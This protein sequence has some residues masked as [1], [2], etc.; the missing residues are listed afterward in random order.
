MRK[1]LS[2]SVFLLISVIL[3]AGVNG[4]K[5]LKVLYIGGSADY[6]V[7]GVAPKPEDVIKRTE[8]FK[9]FL[10][11]YFDSVTV[12]NG[13]DYKPEISYNYD[14]TVIDG[15]IPVIK[16][17]ITERDANGRITKHIKAQLLPEDFDRAVVTI[18][19]VAELVGRA[20]GSKNDWYCLC[21]DADA[22]H[23]VEEHPIFKGPF[24][25]KLTFEKKPTPEDAFHYAYF[26]DGAMP[27]SLMMW[28]VQT[29]GYKTEKGFAV[30]MVSRPWGYTDS[31][32][33]EYIS[34]GVCAKTLDA[35]AIGRHGNFL[36]WGFAASPAYMT[37]EAKTVLANAICYMADFN[38]KGMIA[39]KYSDR[40]ATRE[41]LKE[42]VYMASDEAYTNRVASEEEFNAQCMK[43]RKVAEAKQKEG[44]ELSQNEKRYLNFEPSPVMSRADMLK[45]YQKEAFE[46]FKEDIPAYANY[47]KENRDYFYGG[48]GS[49][50]IVVDE[51]CKAWGI[52]NN[53]PAL[54]EKAISSLEKGVERERALR[55]LD[56]Y[57]LCPFGDDAKAWR[58]WY[59]KYKEDLFFTE[60]GGWIF[61]VNGDA[62]LPGNDYQAKDRKEEEKKAEALTSDMEPVHVSAITEG[63][64]IVFSFK[65]HPG[66]HIYSKVAASDAY[67]PVTVN[68]K[69]PD[70]ISA[71][72]V[73]MPAA[74]NFG[75]NG[76]TIYENHAKISVPLSGSGAGEIICTVG[77]QCCDSHICMPP[78]EKV[79]NIKVNIR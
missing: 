37:E 62:A 66:Y 27:D 19:Q 22:H 50:V 9:V 64:S 72:E 16:P 29:K 20:I 32:D 43:I 6:E 15:K 1:F 38:G 76:T 12:V 65:I 21:L 26:H 10:E 18:G 63:N 33:A 74:K 53:N 46:M 8:A 30:G 58:E 35:V 78:A 44:K 79:F 31:P 51:D 77:W 48:E 71:G 14:V 40:I 60:S 52:A 61:M 39:R 23:L 59:N 55:V 24:K 7:Y 45:R 67:E 13:M 25:T 11:E 70:G 49:Y 3:F 42:L 36:T 17:A 69:T 54:L 2:L 56:R 34:S 41:Y 4:K 28:K 5:S 68:I 75:S 47:Y 73:I 57:T